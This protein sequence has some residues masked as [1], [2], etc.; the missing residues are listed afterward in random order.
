MRILK[1]IRPGSR[2]RLDREELTVS[3]DE[4]M[5]MENLRWQ[6]RLGPKGRHVMT[7]RYGGIDRVMEDCRDYSRR[8][9]DECRLYLPGNWEKGEPERLMAIFEPGGEVS[10]TDGVHYYYYKIGRWCRK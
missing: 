2:P 8:T 1:G 3:F 10:T 9:R 4:L 6:V 5:A 7:A